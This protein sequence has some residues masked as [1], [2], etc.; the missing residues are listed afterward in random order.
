MLSDRYYLLA[1][2]LYEHGGPNLI[3]STFFLACEVHFVF[4][5]QKDVKRSMSRTQIDI[6]S[7]TR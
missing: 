5:R 6:A 2:N 1:D 3:V 7:L 4:I